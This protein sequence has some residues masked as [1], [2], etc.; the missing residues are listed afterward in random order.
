MTALKERERAGKRITTRR[1]FSE[2]PVPRETARRGEGD[3]YTG[4]WE[5]P[6]RKR[7]L[8]VVGK[9]AQGHPSRRGG[10]KGLSGSRKDPLFEG[11]EG[12]E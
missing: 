12:K 6:E 8:L 2:E 4:H 7:P 3:L 10:T 5:L 11:G 1:T 9:K